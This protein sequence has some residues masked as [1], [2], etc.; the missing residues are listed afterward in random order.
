MATYLKYLP[1]NPLVVE[2]YATEGVVGERFQRSRSRAMAVR[3]YVLTRYQLMPQHTGAIALGEEAP[4]SPSKDRW[5]GIALT[6]FLDREQLQFA[7]QPV[8]MR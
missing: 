3:E 5:D 8:A 7:T 1:A 4:G 2:G 6:L